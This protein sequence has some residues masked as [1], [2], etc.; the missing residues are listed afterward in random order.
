MLFPYESSE[1]KHIFETYKVYN[2][3]ANNINLATDTEDTSYLNRNHE[4]LVL[5]ESAAYLYSALSYKNEDGSFST[6]IDIFTQLKDISIIN[7]DKLSSTELY[8]FNFDIKKFIDTVFLL[9]YANRKSIKTYINLDTGVVSLQ[10]N[11]IKYAATIATQ[12]KDSV[13]CNKIKSAYNK[14]IKDKNELKNFIH[15]ESKDALL[16]I[17]NKNKNSY[18]LPYFNYKAYLKDTVSDY[19]NK[20]YIQC[21]NTTVEN[22][23][24]NNSYIC[25][26]NLFDNVNITDKE[27]IKNT[28]AIKYFSATLLENN[29][30]KIDKDLLNLEVPTGFWQA[31]TILQTVK[32]WLFADLYNIEDYS[33]LICRFND[34]YTYFRF[35]NSCILNKDSYDFLDYTKSCVE[36]NKGFDLVGILDSNELYTLNRLFTNYKLCYFDFSQQAFFGYVSKKKKDVGQ[37]PTYTKIELE[38]VVNNVLPLKISFLELKRFIGKKL[39]NKYY[40]LYIYYNGKEVMIKKVDDKNIIENVVIF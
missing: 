4:F 15:N 2:D 24:M 36:Y 16:H 3:Q 13:I 31:L 25:N 1:N 10:I 17:E 6:L 23:I 37:Q 21:Y 14:F 32:Y 7:K 27:Q 26:Y 22:T 34:F 8:I 18:L 19:K 5:T 20:S 11:Y 30:F 35:N 38:N 29:K 33:C 9:D 28:K 39:S 12:I 40:R